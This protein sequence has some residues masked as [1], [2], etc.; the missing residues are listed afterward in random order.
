MPINFL[1]ISNAVDVTGDN[2]HTA[3]DPT[4]PITDAVIVFTVYDSNDVAVPGLTN[5]SMAHVAS[6]NYRGTGT[7]DSALTSGATYTIKV[8]CSNYNTQWEEQYEAKPR[9]FH[10]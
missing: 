6:G 9:N 1:P 7:P 3:A 2:L 4:T 10:Y 8:T 5:I